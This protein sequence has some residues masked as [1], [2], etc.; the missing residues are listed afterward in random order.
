MSRSH[1][2]Q[3][4]NF[5]MI[6]IVLILALASEQ[7]GAAADSEYAV[8]P[9]A[10]VQ[11]VGFVAITAEQMAAEDAQRQ[12]EGLP[13][14]FALPVDVALTPNNAG[15][16]EDLPAGQAL[17]RLRV[18]SP[19]VLS[20]N[21]GFER[22]WLPEGARLLV[23]PA[24]EPGAARRLD[25]GGHTSHGQI[26]TPVFLTDELVVEL[27]VSAADRAL[28][29]LELGSVGRGYR[30]FGEP[31]DEKAGSCNVDVVCPDG[32]GWRNEI[33]SVGL[34]QL[35]G[36]SLCTG[37]MVN[38]ATYD[39]RPLFMTAFH[40]NVDE[41][42]APSLVVYWN[43]QSP[44]CGDQS[45]GELTQA[46]S[47]STLL[48]AY[49]TSDFTLLELDQA[50]DLAF[51]VKYAGWNRSS[52][53]PDGAVCIHHPVGDEKSI[54][55][56]NDALTTTG[57]LSPTPL[58]G[59][60]DHLRVA[61]WDVGTTEVGSSGS[62]LF[63][64]QHRV[65]GQLHGGYAACGINL[66]DWYGR[67]SVSWE[68][69]GAVT[70]RLRDHLDPGNTGAMT[71]DIFDPLAA[72][73]SVT[74]AGEVM[75]TKVSGGPVGPASHTYIVANVGS[76]LVNF[77]VATATDWLSLDT[78]GGLVA[79]GAQ[80]EVLVTLNAMTDELPL[81]IH[82]G[83]IEYTN[84]DGGGGSTSRDVLLTVAENELTV[85]GAVPNPFSAVP[86][87]IRYVLL[88]NTSVRAQVANLRG[89]KVR[90]LGTFAGVVGENNILWDGLDDH[91]QLVPSG[92]YVVT[93]EGLGRSYQV[94]LA[95]TH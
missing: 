18:A 46:S 21:L 30:F 24:D 86:V 6:F 28:V 12:A 50:P 9:L 78:V 64:L 29:D 83:T 95:Y 48:A 53:D 44:V 93:I 75:S 51:G 62:P 69:G 76:E 4:P 10:D 91:G 74:P 56:E 34:V 16:W 65:V 54:S 77:T 22:A 15:T 39:G 7:A 79:V 87:P 92:V 35:R 3:A 71:T 67:F 57:Y 59:T 5:L 42:S 85:V 20:L 72:S 25:G 66:A 88:G 14:R 81:G 41:G 17:W 47:G 52:A 43:Y 82:R 89:F 94:K 73:F 2:C 45:G 84:T 61:D 1:C 49:G 60:G 90:D 55:F 23:Y 26:W 31:A 33:D 68:G 32:D 37:F 27:L 58:P 19:G 70:S 13:Y 38:N 80:V 8:R 40:C 63:D 36:A 11:Q